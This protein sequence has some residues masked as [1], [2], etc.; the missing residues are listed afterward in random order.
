MVYK[1]SRARKLR[2]KVNNYSA[3]LIQRL[4]RTTVRE[5]IV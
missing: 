3:C 4:S 1:N 2:C 5:M